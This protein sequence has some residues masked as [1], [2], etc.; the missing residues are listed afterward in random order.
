MS[1][2]FTIFR[3]ED[4]ETVLLMLERCLQPDFMFLLVRM[5]DFDSAVA[6]H[7]AFPTLW[8]L[9]T[10][11]KDYVRWFKCHLY[12]GVEHPLWNWKYLNLS[13]Y[14]HRITFP[15]Y[16]QYVHWHRHG[17]FQRGAPQYRTEIL[18]F[19]GMPPL[20]DK[21][22]VKECIFLP[23]SSPPSIWR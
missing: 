21:F 22:V 3:M 16:V 5:L 4:T 10:N 15:A 1:F 19:A 7:D 9:W 18:Q 17:G 12:G 13:D 23:S 8:R 11:G 20:E 2:Q 14:W 6:F